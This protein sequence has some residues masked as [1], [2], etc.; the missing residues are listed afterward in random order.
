MLNHNDVD[1][2]QL[3]TEGK[4]FKWKRPICPKCSGKVWGHGFVLTFFNGFPDLL[5]I[6][7]YRCPSKSCRKVIIMRPSGFW[8]KFQTNIEEIFNALVDRLEGLSWP[9]GVPRQRG[10][11]W[12][13]KFINKMKMLYGLDNE[14]IGLGERLRQFYKKS[15]HFFN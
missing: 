15:L 2:N 3:S 11:H 9:L 8:K 7:R 12:L 6:K 10:G 14:G 4:N 1:L 13:R 5:F